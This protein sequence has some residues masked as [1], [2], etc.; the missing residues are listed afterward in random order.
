MEKTIVKTFRLNEEELKRYNELYLKSGC[1]N[2]SDFIKS[3]ILHESAMDRR[4]AQYILNSMLNMSLGVEE[5]QRGVDR[6]YDG[7][8]DTEYEEKICNVKHAINGVEKEVKGLYGYIKT[9]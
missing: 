2:E 1:R 8:K 3:R 4:M 6:L 5:A 9:L 7:L